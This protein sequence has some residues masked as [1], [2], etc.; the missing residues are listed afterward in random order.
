MTDWRWSAPVVGVVSLLSGV[1]LMVFNGAS[2]DPSPVVFA[3]RD[4]LENVPA[5]ATHPFGSEAQ[6]AR[7]DPSGL[8]LIGAIGVSEPL[9]QPVVVSAEQYGRISAVFVR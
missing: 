6:G 2:S 3:A 7:T 1:V 9:G 5:Q 8:N 4:G